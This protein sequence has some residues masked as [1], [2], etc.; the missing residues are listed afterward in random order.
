MSGCLPLRFPRG[1]GKKTETGIVK[2]LLPPQ[3][4]IQRKYSFIETLAL[5]RSSILISINRCSCMRI[6]EKKEAL[7]TKR[8]ADI[9]AL[10]TEPWLNIR[11]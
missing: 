5:N 2:C 1:L 11:I 6:P 7:S 8:E 10:V 3:Y 4:H 9:W